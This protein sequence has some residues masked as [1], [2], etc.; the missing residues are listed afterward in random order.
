MCDAYP[1]TRL[2]LSAGVHQ[3]LPKFERV[4]PSTFRAVSTHHLLRLYLNRVAGFWRRPSS[5]EVRAEFDT[6]STSSTVSIGAS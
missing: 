6:G 3:G 4:Q 1:S 2:L 5:W